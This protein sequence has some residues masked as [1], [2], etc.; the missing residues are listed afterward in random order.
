MFGVIRRKKMK[1]YERN[2]SK[3][4]HPEDMKL[5]LDYLNAHGRI[6]VKE[7]T[8]EELYYDFSDEKYCA[9][10]MGV[11]DRMLEEFEDWLCDIEI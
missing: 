9:C 11:N 10:W 2:E 4:N 1:A 7:S 3:F 8:I 6:L 5:I